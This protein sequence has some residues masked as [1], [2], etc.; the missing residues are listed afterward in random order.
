MDDSQFFLTIVIGLAILIFNFWK[1]FD[2]PLQMLNTKFPISKYSITFLTTKRRYILAKILYISVIIIIYLCL[3]LAVRYSP[4]AVKVFEN[5]AQNENLNVNLKNEHAW[6]KSLSDPFTLAL[7]IT[8]LQQ[9]PIINEIEKYFR[10]IF[11]AVAQIPEKVRKYV[12]QLRAS[13]FQEE[14]LLWIQ[15]KKFGLDFEKVNS[16]EIYS[17]I[18]EDEL[19]NIWLTV[20]GIIVKISPTKQ[21]KKIQ[22]SSDFIDQNKD[23]LDSIVDKYRGLFQSIKERASKIYYNTEQKANILYND[24]SSLLE[25]IH[26][27]RDRLYTFVACGVISSSIREQDIDESFELLGFSGKISP[28]KDSQMIYIFCYAFFAFIVTFFINMIA[29]NYFY[30]LFI[31]PLGNYSPFFIHHIPNNTGD[32]FAK[33]SITASFYIP[34]VIFCLYLRKSYLSAYDWSDFN[35][36]KIESYF[37]YPYEKYALPIVASGAIGSACFTLAIIIYNQFSANQVPFSINSLLPW[38]P[39]AFIV[40]WQ[41]LFV[42]DRNYNITNTAFYKDILRVS[43]TASITIFFISLLLTSVVIKADEIENFHQNFKSDE[44]NFQNALNVIYYTKLFIASQITVFCFMLF[45][46]IRGFEVKSST[47]YNIFNNKLAVYSGE[48]LLFE[49]S[50]D[51]LGSVKC[52]QL[53]DNG[54]SISGNWRHFPEGIVIKWENSEDNIH[55]LNRLG[56]ITSIRGIQYYYGYDGKISE[57]PLFCYIVK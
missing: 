38:Y 47:F 31:D 27:L 41:A 33:T 14:K 36:S 45:L 56:L 51:K 20:G 55:N 26:A 50:L 53:N 18:I 39:L 25:E 15:V 30:E 40:S 37:Q 7:L 9:M 5:I 43:I 12:S 22:I 52:L 23:E 49:I 44:M 6:I 21:A 34:A 4:T 46:V 3:L 19:I 42:C 10:S 48:N 8:T 13:V 28:S 24:N 1:R 29:T 17:K 32:I 2:V 54:K 35:E 57:N 16:K 11:H